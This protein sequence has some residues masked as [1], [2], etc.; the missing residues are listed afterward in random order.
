MAD[1]AAFAELAMEH[2]P[3]LYTA[4]LRMTRNAAD[5]ED[6]VQETYLKAYRGFGSFSEGTNL[7]AWLYRIL[8]NTYINA[9]RAAKRRPEVSDV[10]DVED[11]YLYHRIA[12]EDGSTRSA[13]EEVLAGFTDDEVKAAIEALPDAFRIA[14]L[15]ADVEGFS[16][17]EIAE[18]TDVPIGTVMSRIHRG[19]RALEKT[20]AGFA[21]ERGLVGA[22]PVAAP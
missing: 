18:I 19:R 14:V 5:A 10:E 20:L 12:P 11:L 16:Y 4:A 3:A 8:T 6:L 15:L 17:K 7:K 1:R 21:Q 9:Y 13:E 2:M 22:G